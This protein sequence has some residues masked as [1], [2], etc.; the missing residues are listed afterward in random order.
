MHICIVTAFVVACLQA[1]HSG[2][3]LNYMTVS[4]VLRQSP[5]SL[6]RRKSLLGK[7]PNWRRTCETV[8]YYVALSSRC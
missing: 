4:Q 2:A 1:A 8:I 5:S 7:G 3:W 6:G